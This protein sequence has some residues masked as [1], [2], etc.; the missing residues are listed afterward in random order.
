MIREVPQ[1][2]EGLPST[3][4]TLEGGGL[5]ATNPRSGEKDQPHALNRLFQFDMVLPAQ[6]SG[7]HMGER[8]HVRFIHE[9][10]SLG[11][12]MA[13]RVR[14]LFLSHLTL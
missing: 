9:P 11:T 4:L 1:G 5:I 12:R 10:E 14:Q 13:R 3:A 8:A 6:A 2:D 7:A